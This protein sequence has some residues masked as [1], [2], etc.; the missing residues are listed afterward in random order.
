MVLSERGGFAAGEEAVEVLLLLHVDHGAD[1]LCKQVGVGAPCRRP[2]F[3]ARLNGRYTSGSGSLRSLQ[4]AR[5]RSSKL[6][7]LGVVGDDV[8]V[9]REVDE[10]VRVQAVLLVDVHAIVAIAQREDDAG[11]E[12][13]ARGCA[14][15]TA[16]SPLGRLAR[17][18]YVFDVVEQVHAEVVEAEV[19]DGDAGLEVF[20]LDDFV[21][22]PAELLLAVGDVVGSWRRAG[23]RRRWRRRRRSPCGSRRAP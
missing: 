12:A 17:S 6:L 20:Q 10:V 14:G 11:H 4:A 19:G 16:C 13:H 21:L 23:C 3:V 5:A 1:R 8:P 2:S 22:E 7:H 18:P 9:V 15:T